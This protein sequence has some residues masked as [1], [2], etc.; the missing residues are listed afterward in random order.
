MKWSGKMSED[1]MIDTFI[2][3]IGVWVGLFIGIY[4]L[5]KYRYK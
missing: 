1:I 3:L 4:C 2:F 5:D